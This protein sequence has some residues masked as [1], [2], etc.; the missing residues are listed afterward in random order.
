MKFNAA[1]T[2][3]GWV[4]RRSM[5]RPGNI[6]ELETVGG[7]PEIRRKDVLP[8]P[9]KP[10]GRM[11]RFSKMGFAAIAF[12]LEDAG[13]TGDSSPKDIGLV[14]STWTGCME[15]DIDY[16]RT[17]LQNAPS[18]ALFA[19]TLDSC[20]LGEAS[21]CFGLTGEHYVI[22]E[23]CCDGRS[24]L[25]F[26]LES[27][28]MGPSKAFVCGICNSGINFQG[29]TLSLFNALGDRSLLTAELI[30]KP[31]REFLPGALFFVLEPPGEDSLMMISADSPQSIYDSDN[32]EIDDIFDLVIKYSPDMGILN[33]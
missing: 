28:C 19:Y 29:R 4:G 1:I 21:I 3:L 22:N 23:Q 32:H 5:G 26:A 13:M 25:F 20:F 16:W 7:L 24:A 33:Q 15:T 8:R 31:C 17:V 18:P 9:Y 14:A 27:L 12:A 10:F 2:G 30:K 11:D 6:R